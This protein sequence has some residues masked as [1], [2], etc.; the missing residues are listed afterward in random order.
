[1]N[2]PVDVPGI[3][4]PYMRWA[5]HRPHPRFDLAIS[6]LLAC[7]LDDL[8]GA[9]E[10]L[11]I[12]G[13]NDE[14]WAPLLE[15]IA[16]R[17]GTGVE[18]VVTATGASGANFLALAATLRPGDEVLVE[19]P[20]YDPLIGAARMLGAR[21]ARF[22]RAW[23][24]GFALDPDRVEAALSPATR[25]VVVSDPHNPSGVMASPDVLDEIGERAA[26][27]GAH[28]LVDEVYLDGV[29]DGRRPA[30]ASRSD[31]FISTSSLTKAYGL[32]G[33]RCGWAMSAPG[34]AEAMRRVRDVV[35]GTG[36]IPAERLSCVAFRQI[37]RLEA[38]ARSILEPNLKALVGFVESRDELEWVAP[39][40]GNVAFPRIR[41]VD[42]TSAFT[43]NLL[44]RYETAVVPGHFFEAPGHFRLGYGCA[45]E[46]M[47]EGLARIGR[48]LDELG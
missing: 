1:M 12:N 38:R 32:A 3:W 45:P 11:D 20:A 41:G 18:C 46:I 10:A 23:E 14:G 13:P 35:D 8:P 47:T 2:D 36:S 19:R 39:D 28:V 48:A 29:F 33:L 22:D 40:G 44:E 25:L 26:G 30:A 27:A 16:A 15:L 6:N 31:A 5:K 42:D 21:V 43:E 4:A 24:D 37:D 34:L 7:S 17:Y 9:L